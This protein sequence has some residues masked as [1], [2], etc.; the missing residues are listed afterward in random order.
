MY[1]FDTYTL[2]EIKKRNV[3][4]VRIKVILREPVQGDTLRTAAEKAFR[5]FPYYARKVVVNVQDAYELEPC[6]KPITV[7]PDD[8]TV[9]LGS[10]ETNELLFAITYEGNNIYFNFSHNFCGGC[11]AMR[12]IK[13]TLWQ[14]LTDLGHTI[15]TRGIMTADT[16]MNA[17]EYKAP[18]VNSLPSDP[19]TG[20]P[21]FS[22]DS[23]TLTADYMAFMKNP[24]RKMGYYPISIP[25]SELMKYARDN[26]GSPN[27]IISAVLFRMFTRLF[28]DQTKFSVR[29]ACNYRADVGCPET[30]RDMVRQ[31]QVSYPIKIKDWTTEKISTV[32]RSKMYV[33][34]QP[35]Y[36]WE[37]CR[38]VDTFR[39]GID[40]QPDLESKVNFAVE[41]SPV[42][43]GIPS[44]CVIS[45]V[46]KV[47]WNGLAPH[48]QGVYS[49]TY[50]HV[51]LEINATEENFCISFQ[52]L[53]EHEKYIR[54]F[55]EVLAEEGVSYTVGEFAD[56][57]LPEIVLPPFTE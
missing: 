18:D 1:D 54:A 35:E 33:Q 29:I 21:D 7:A 9:R 48:I 5:R 2:Y 57:R 10:T 4:S 15:D 52:T 23:F 44:T 22:R 36:S 34:M 13:A 45:Y 20:D 39:R 24:D 47:D 11:G 8:H 43:H 53:H 32:T 42:T 55:L 19:P 40:G 46:G 27:S 6:E 50:G 31:I 12:W 51:M 30:Y 26:D 37:A 49:L 25:K 14:Y 38:K 41:N 16:P 56:R 3:Y 28:P 17:E